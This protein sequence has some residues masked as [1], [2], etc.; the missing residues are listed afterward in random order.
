MTSTQLSDFDTTETYAE[1]NRP[2]EPPDPDELSIDDANLPDRGFEW[3]DEIRWVFD[4]DVAVVQPESAIELNGDTVGEHSVGFVI[5]GKE[6]YLAEM[7]ETD[8]KLHPASSFDDIEEMEGYYADLTT[9]GFT[10]GFWGWGIPP[11]RIK[12][13]VELAADGHDYRAADM[14]IT[15]C[16]NRGFIIE[17]RGKAF[18]LSVSKVGKPKKTVTTRTIDG[19]TIENELNEEVLDGFHRVKPIIKDAFGITIT[20]FEK[21]DDTA[22]YFTVEEYDK[23]LKLKG[24]HLKSAVNCTSNI[25]EVTAAGKVET[26]HT[27]ETYTYDPDPEAIQNKPDEFAFEKSNKYTLGYRTTVNRLDKGLRENAYDYAARVLATPYYLKVSPD[28]YDNR[29]KTR[30]YRSKSKSVIAT[31]TY[32]NPDHPNPNQLDNVPE[33]FEDICEEYC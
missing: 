4:N 28:R 24:S 16:G 31:V 26:L 20:G 22:L 5:A 30:I 6:K 12:Q 9:D 23:P 13:A 29:I 32:E 7:G 8:E 15:P 2:P 11:E 10:S 19:I 18:M 3:D 21:R 25:D 17:Y 33:T 1:S 14:E 27:D